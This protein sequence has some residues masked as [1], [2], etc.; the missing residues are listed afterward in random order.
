MS[1][2]S[3]SVLDATWPTI[4]ST[5]LATASTRAYRRRRHEEVATGERE[6][7]RQGRR[8]RTGHRRVHQA[9]AQQREDLAAPALEARRGVQ[10]V[11]Q[12]DRARAAQAER[13]DPAADRE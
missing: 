5:V 6:P 11:P 13:G 9:A 3:G 10:P 2:R 8:P 12:P 4:A 7:D 1:C